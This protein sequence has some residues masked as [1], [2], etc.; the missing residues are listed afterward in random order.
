MNAEAVKQL[1]AEGATRREIARGL[2]RRSSDKPRAIWLMLPAGVVQA[3]ARPAGRAARPRRHGDRRRQLLLPRRHHPGQAARRQAAPLR[4]LRHARRGVG[5]RARLLPHD[6]RRETERVQ[7]L[8]PIFKTIAP[9]VGTAE[10]TPGRT[11]DGTAPEGYLHCGPSG[12]G[13]FVKMVHN[14]VEYGMMAAIAEGPQ[15]HQARQRGQAGADRRRRDHPAARSRGLPVRHRRRRGGG[16]V[17]AR[18]G[19]LARGWSTCIADALA[20][21]PHLDDFRG[22]VS[23]S[24]EG[25]WTRDRR[26]S[27]RACPG[28]GHQ[29]ARCTSGSTRAGSG[30]FADEIA[31]RDAQPS[32]A[33]TPRRRTRPLHASRTRN[34]A[35]TPPP[36]P[37]PRPAYVAERAREAVADQRRFTLRGQRRPHAVGDVRRTGHRRR[38]RGTQSSSSRSTSGS[39]RT[40]TRTGTSTHL[41]ESLG[42][43][44]AQVRPD[45][46]RTRPTWKAAAADYAGFAAGRFDLVHLGLGPDGHTASLSPAI[47]CSPYRS[48]WSRSPSRTRAIRG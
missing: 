9:G 7:R 19:G 36:W 38:S 28:P 27:T 11:R 45:A 8:D 23:D 29:R 48:A 33:A 24:G 16:G 40:A 39:P 47:R 4:R 26:R 12:A 15:H 25:R 41:R 35:P 18:L 42:P 22:R 31:V 5:A 34:A 43:A 2:R 32:S 13:H 14:G 3:D 10:P 37:R 20:R 17:A 21:S 30:E 1:E 6:R 46:G 44:A